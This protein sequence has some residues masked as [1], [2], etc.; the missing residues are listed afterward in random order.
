[1]KSARHQFILLGLICQGLSWDAVVMPLLNTLLWVA[2]LTWPRR[3]APLGQTADMA[4][5]VLG[6][7]LAWQLAPVFGVSAHF[8]VGH[9]LVLL[10]LLRLLRPLD[11]REKLFS[12]I[13]ASGHLAVACTVI[14]DYRFILILL[15]TLLLLPKALLELE[16]E[17]FAGAP[18][19]PVKL[20]RLGFAAASTIF[21][22]MAAVFVLVPRG[23]LGTPLAAR[24]PGG[25]PGDAL[26]TVLDPSRGGAANSSKLLLQVEAAE[27]GYLRMMALTEFA[28]GE[29]KAEAVPAWTPLANTSPSWLAGHRHRRV[30]VK[31]VAVLNR[32]LPTDGHPARV[33]GRFFRTPGCTAQGIVVC[34]AMWNS[35]NNVYEYWV[36]PRPPAESLRD[37]QRN[38]LLAHP[39]PSPQLRAWLD[40]VLAGATEPHTQARRLEAHLRDTF[41]YEL[42]APELSRL[43]ALEEF[44]LKERRGHCERFASALALLL[45]MQGVP[46]RV[47]VGFVP[48]ERNWL[49][50]WRDVRLRDA[51]AWVEAHFA[52]RGWVQLDATPRAT[53]PPPGWE[54]AELFDALDVIWYLNIVNFDATAQRTVF[55]VSTQGFGA[56]VEQ[57]RRFGPTLLGLGALVACGVWLKRRWP[58]RLKSAAS[59]SAASASAQFASDTYGR[60]LRLLARRGHTRQAHETPREFLASLHG[61]PVA[62]VEPVERVTAAFCAT[63]YGARVL[64]TTEQR[65]LEGA[66]A[67]LAAVEVMPAAVG[68]QTG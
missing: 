31:E 40:K 22:V 4:A 67:Q 33:T 25:A 44:L 16:T 46:A 3:P 32:V 20:P 47:A 7:V 38:R 34:E 65:E 30:R 37:W 49:S 13:V 29:W 52:E 11:R 60:M 42:G 17:N 26:D 8:A 5:I 18:G 39:A 19:T 62:V 23:F 59:P 9:G 6:G 54:P 24:L 43:N 53:L 10:Q 57:A 66:L 21:A 14:L 15:A 1:M 51:H 35:G 48:G 36:N 61:E 50:G 12:L 68:R 28:G 45:R 2:C 55:Q 63:R 27:V 56:A 41:K 64:S 58:A